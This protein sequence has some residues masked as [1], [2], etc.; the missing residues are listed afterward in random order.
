MRDTLRVN[1]DL[2]HMT[3]LIHRHPDILVAAGSPVVSNTSPHQDSSQP[4]R[5]SRRRKVNRANSVAL[6]DKL[7]VN[8]QRKGKDKRV[9]KRAKD[10]IVSL[11]ES[12]PSS[13]HLVSRNVDSLLLNLSLKE[14]VLNQLEERHP[15]TS[16][17]KRDSQERVVRSSKKRV[18]NRSQAQKILNQGLLKKNLTKNL[19]KEVSGNS[20]L[21]QRKLY[22]GRGV[23]RRKNPSLRRRSHNRSLRKSLWKV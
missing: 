6:K 2:S 1:G 3:S 23:D 5:T 19:L 13:H 10:V 18:I 12:S 8:H 4:L 16:S 21:A 20:V 7:R 17:S 22:L 11:R 14:Q 15:K 9:K